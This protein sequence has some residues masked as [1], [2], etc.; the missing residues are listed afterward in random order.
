MQKALISSRNNYHTSPVGLIPDPTDTSGLIETCQEFT[1]GTSLE[2]DL[3]HHHLLHSDDDQEVLLGIYSTIYWSQNS[4]LSAEERPGKNDDFLQRLTPAIS[5][6]NSAAAVTAVKNTIADLNHK[7]HALALIEINK[8]LHSN[9]S[10]ASTILAFLDPENI[11]VFDDRLITLLTSGE[12]NLF[13]GD[14][15]C[16]ALAR[17]KTET[18]NDAASRFALYCTVLGKIKQRVN[19]SRIGWKDPTGCQMFRFRSID[20]QRALSAMITES[21]QAF[22]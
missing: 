10:T 1:F 8:L 15:I 17:P 7:H 22:E 12:W 2:L 14:E 6:I 16:R 19:Q 13:L 21:E 9:L 18:L 11:G 20:V 4:F 5:S 3:H